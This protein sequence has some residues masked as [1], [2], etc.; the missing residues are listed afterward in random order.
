MTARCRTLE[1]AAWRR[2]LVL[3][4]HP[5][6]E[7]LAT[8]GLLQRV[9]ASG[10]SLRVVFAT[11]GENNPWP[12]R[13]LERRW[14]ID[15]AGRARWAARRRAETLAALACLGVRPADTRFLHL[16][17]QGLTRLLLAG[18]QE[19]VARLAHELM[20]GPTLVVAPAG[21][22]RHPDHSALAALL[23]LTVDRLPHARRRFDQLA[24]VVH[25]DVGSLAFALR[26]GLRERA[27]KRA[28][29]ACH[30]T[31]LVLSRRRFL[32]HLRAAE[33]FI[34]PATASPAHR[35]RTAIYGRGSIS[36]F[37]EAPRGLAVAS[38]ATLDV[39]ALDRVGTVD[40]YSCRV[41][42]WRRRVA[43]AVGRTPARLLVKCETPHL[44]FDDAGWREIALPSEAEAPARAVVGIA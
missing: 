32:S 17:D 31:Q 19:V 37:L 12:Q 27:G 26:L 36:L 24:Y 44:F 23:R 35:V 30:G 18:N 20:W 29:M 11:D 13:V 42:P 43:L 15:A 39:L 1:E 5:D 8:G 2:V 22:D 40:R 25:G 16:P 7:T 4:P 34:D 28:A 9:V 21:C 41:A 33:R 14:R 3:A 38:P 6:D 10:G